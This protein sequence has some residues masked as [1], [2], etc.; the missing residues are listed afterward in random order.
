MPEINIRQMLEAGIH[1]GHRSCYW[2]PGM[3][4]YLYGTRSG[5]HIFNLEETHRLLH[6]ACNFVSKLAAEH[7][8]LLFVGTKR[9]ARDPIAQAAIACGMP[10]VN[11]RWLGGMMTNF[12]TVRKS[13]SRM[14]EIEE[15]QKTAGMNFG[16]KKEQLMMQ[17]LHDKINRNLGGIRDMTSLPDALFV[18]DVGMEKIAIVEAKKLGIPVVGVVDSNHSPKNIDYPIPGND[19][20]I[21]A[22]KFYIEVI[23]QAVL[24]GKEI[25]ALS[26]VP[27]PG[28]AQAAVEPE[29]AGVV[30][31]KGVVVDVQTKTAATPD[32]QDASAD[33]VADASA[34]A[35][36]PDTADAV[37]PDTAEAS[38]EAATPEVAPE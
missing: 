2:D 20:A 33:A 17:R 23:S 1:F 21:R 30:S 8:K 7:K 4:P 28:A 32:K 37:A 9:V 5:V 11:R 22:V 38:P 34:D 25:A 31:S 10:Y 12:K 13:V 29:P 26:L 19:D 15:R 27:T 35:V 14:Q 36:A 18:L 24:T 3:A 6:E 16:K